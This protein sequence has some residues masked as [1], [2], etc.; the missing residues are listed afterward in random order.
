MLCFSSCDDVLQDDGEEQ[1]CTTGQN[2]SH[3][4]DE[5]GL[6]DDNA[7]S[8]DDE[9]DVQWEG[10]DIGPAPPLEAMQA[11]NAGIG[12]AFEEDGELAE[13]HE[14]A[15]EAEHLAGPL[16]VSPR[17][18]PMGQHANEGRDSLLGG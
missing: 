18:I 10:A 2:D 5:E 11:E 9:D 1:G 7:Q 8:T 15:V 3:D 17:H 16:K 4:S 6:S 13:E 12:A 14:D